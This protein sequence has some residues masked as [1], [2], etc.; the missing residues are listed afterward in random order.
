MWYTCAVILGIFLLWFITDLLVQCAVYILLVPTDGIRQALHALWIP[1]RF[2]T[3]LGY[4]PNFLLVGLYYMYQL[5]EWK[6]FRTS[7]VWNWMRS[8]H[9][10]QTTIVK[11]EKGEEAEKPIIYA[12]C[13]HGVYS[14]STVFH[15]V[16][17]PDYQH[18]TAVCTSLLFYIPIVREFTCLAGAIPAN[19][20]PIVD[21]LDAGKSIILMPEGLR[22]VL[23]PDTMTI[24]RGSEENKPRYGFIQRALDSKRRHDICIVPVY[25]KGENDL[26]NV[27]IISPYL[28]SFLLRKYLYPWPIFAWGWNWLPFWPKRNVPVQIIF[29]KSISLQEKDRLKEVEQIHKEYCD[30][31]ERLIKM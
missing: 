6:A 25:Y 19:A 21:A 9:F 28:Q 29:G 10:A 26:Y 27:K 2:I 3:L 11:T 31:M 8:L 22:G 4:V 13:P 7:R 15:F 1:H 20:R 17:H 18:V 16:L 24:L 23:Q 14:T 12:A 30:E 5:P